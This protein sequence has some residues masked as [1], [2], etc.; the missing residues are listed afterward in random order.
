MTVT[1]VDPLLNDPE[2][3]FLADVFLACYRM[4]RG[5]RRYRLFRN[6]VLLFSHDLRP[7]DSIYAMLAQTAA[8]SVDDVLSELRAAVDG[9]PKPLHEMFNRAFNPP[10]LP[11]EIRPFNVEMTR[12]DELDYVLSFLGTT[13][14]Y[15]IVTNYPKYEYVE[16][17]PEQ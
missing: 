9:L 10:L 16:L 6:A 14:L 1:R 12:S 8:I 5:T 17:V 3:N 11:Y 2:I 15:I 4:D 13:F 7:H